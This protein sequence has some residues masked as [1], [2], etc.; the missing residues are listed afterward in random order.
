MPGALVIP[1]SQ[2]IEST[3]LESREKS[4]TPDVRTKYAQRVN[5]IY[6]ND[7]TMRYEHDWLQ[8]PGQIRLVP[9]YNT[10]TVNVTVDTAVVTGVGTTWTPAMTGRVIKFNSNNEYYTFTYVSPTSGTLSQA[11]T[12]LFG[13]GN[14]VDGGYTIYQDKYDLPS[15]YTRMTVEPGVY[16]TINFGRQ[17]VLNADEENF[18]RRATQ[19]TADIALY[20]REY[21]QRTNLGLMQ[22]QLTPPPMSQRDIYFEY[23]KALPQMVE[24]RTGTATVSAGGVTVTFSG[25][26]TGLVTV[27]QYFRLDATGTWIQVIDVPSNTTATLAS[28]YPTAGSSAA[29]TVS[30]APDMPPEMHEVV[31]MGACWQAAQDQNSPEAATRFSEYMRSMG[32][33]M[34]IRARKRYG[35]Q[36]L[37]SWRI[38]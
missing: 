19:V 30:D 5:R 12:N 17:F 13:G 10:G 14:I 25:T 20:W 18:R 26:I 38:R 29:F 8:K 11:L 37:K 31:Y 32:M 21:Q 16:Y 3:M 6:T 4:V 34:S 33:L 9:A 1:F 2:L 15:D 35:R 28:G 23:I 27:G 36:Y 24:Y 7:I 22:I